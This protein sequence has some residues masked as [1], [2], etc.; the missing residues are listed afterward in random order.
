MVVSGFEDGEDRADYAR[1]KYYEAQN[2]GDDDTPDDGVERCANCGMP[3]HP[4][5]TM[6]FVAQPRRQAL[7][8]S[9]GRCSTCGFDF[10][11]DD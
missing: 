5:W 2:A 6:I 3:L 4:T 10:E 1:R 7:L 8:D 11:P 9:E